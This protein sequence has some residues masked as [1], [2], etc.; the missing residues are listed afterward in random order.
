[1]AGALD[2]VRVIDFG[3]YMAGPLAAQLLADQG[4]DV[5]RVDPPSG[6]LWDT[7]ANATWNRG[8]RSIAIDLKQEAGLAEASRLVAS[9]DV[10]IE[11]F[12]PGVM[13]RLGLGPEALTE[14]HPALVYL[15]LPGFGADD[16]R[17][18]VPGWEG[19]V[20]AA[21]ATYRPNP[22]RDSDRPVYTAIPIASGYAALLGATSGGMA[23]LARER[24]GR[25]QRVEVPLYDAMYTAIG[26]YG[27]KITDGPARPLRAS[28]WVRQYECQDGRW[29]QF[30]A[31]FTRFIMQFID[32]AG[33]G[34]WREDGVTDRHRVRDEPELS[35]EL[36][37]RMRAL[38]KTRPAL[39]WEELVNAAGTPTAIC[40][41][42]A[43]WLAHPHARESEMIVEVDDP[44]YGPMLQPGVQARLG[45]TPGEVRGP[46][47]ELDGDRKAILAE[48]EGAARN[49][50]GVEREDPRAVLDGVK[51]LDLC[52]ILAGPTC[53]RTLGEFGADVIKIDG[54]S[55]EDGVLFH[56]DVN[57]AKRSLL[58]DLK[59]E[60]GRDIFW[61]LVDDADV[62]VQN[63]RKGVVD[64]LG[65]G[66]EEVR[67]R[68]PD[69]VYASLNAYGH[70]G[71]WAD[72]PGWEQLAQAATGMQERFG[73]EAPVLQ[74]YAI[75]DYGTGI[76]GAYAVA[77]ALLHRRRT[78]EGQHV[79]AALAYT[80]CTLQ[81]SFL[82]DY[83]GKDWDEPRGQEALGSGPLQRLYR[84][85]DGWFFLGARES[86]VAAI[87][88]ISG[89]ES[90]E[91]CSPEA[92]GPFLE[93][94]FA[95]APV[96]TWVEWL[97]EAG[98]GAH[99]VASIE[100][101]MEDPRAVARGFSLTRQH[102]DA[103]LIRTTGPVAMLSRTPVRPGDP[104]SPPGLD[105][106]SI[107]AE[108]GMDEALADLIAEGVVVVDGVPAL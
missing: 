29:V 57:R 49:G 107:L 66:Y 44:R 20:A 103:G 9:A 34:E 73:G 33:V 15:S 97:R 3:Q 96:E 62:I 98:C 92:L 70:D 1:M 87:A 72:R 90:A 106:P 86:D 48:L 8:K 71:P 4:A 41:T 14:R 45:G 61:R 77:L 54:P 104:A 100:E 32:A 37:R 108:I 52:I 53:G 43:E 38:F 27:L 6:P 79:N 102:E 89:L 18:S 24:D 64:R 47:P 2:G 99:R 93:A 22:E 42:T 68:R 16:P 10:V 95:S 91:Q 59:T 35:D 19:V 82:Q 17:A 56:H 101:V 83:A 88:S 60:K 46:A 94:R 78:G 75:N 85:S 74:P 50:A 40:R 36:E 67:K 105:A 28:P 12:R 69:I 65:I 81:S 23:L 80:A 7:P 21:S 31:A 76:T 25:G 5:V 84:A 30:H 39:E 55:R 26:L 63:Y 58:L 11:N 13:E 51:V